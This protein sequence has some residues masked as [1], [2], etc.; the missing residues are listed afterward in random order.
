[1]D[2]PLSDEELNEIERRVTDPPPFFT[3]N[4]AGPAE[5][6]TLEHLLGALPEDIA[7]R[8]RVRNAE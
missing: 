6:I 1:M 5:P 4:A 2:F 3:T 7:N 8:W